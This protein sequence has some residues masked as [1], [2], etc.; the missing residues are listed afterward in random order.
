MKV[1]LKL[2]LTNLGSISVRLSVRVC[3][4]VCM[5]SVRFVKKIDFLKEPNF[6]LHLNYTSFKILI[7]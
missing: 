6:F 2:V 4:C 1:K 5:L 3:V 7:K